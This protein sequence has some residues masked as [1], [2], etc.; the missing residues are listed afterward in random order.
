MN[1][2][3]ILTLACVAT[4]AVTSSV[5][6]TGTP[7]ITFV[8]TI[9][10]GPDSSY[11]LDNSN[12]ATLG[13]YV[14]FQA[15]E[16]TYGNELW[17][18]N[19]TTTELVKDIYAGTNGSSPDELTTIGS[20]IYFKASDAAHGSELWRTDG[21]AAGTIRLSDIRAGA[22]SSMPDEIMAIGST[23][24][25]KAVGS[26]IGAELYKWNGSSV[27]LVQDLR[28][29]ADAGSDPT[30]LTTFGDH[31]YFVANDGTHGQEL[32]RIGSTGMPELVKDINVSGGSSPGQLYAASS[33][34]YFQANDGE[35]GAEL[36]RTDGTEAGTVMVQN[37][38]GSAGS[39]P[40]WMIEFNGEIYFQATDNNAGE[41]PGR[42]LF[43]TNGPSAIE[44]VS[45][46]RDGNDGS[47]PEGL[48]VLGSRLFF[49]ADDG[50]NGTELWSY[51]GTS[52]TLF[53]LNTGPGNSYPMY[54]PPAV[55]G[56]A[57][58]FVA[59]ANESEGD[60]YRI[61]VED[62][63]PTLVA[64]SDATLH[65]SWQSCSSC[66]WSAPGPL[67]AAQGRLFFSFGYDHPSYGNE[68]AYLDEPTYVLPSTN[69]DGSALP[70]ILVFAAALTAAASTALRRR[71][72]RR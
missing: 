55:V 57:L 61:G 8:D 31:I 68:F 53:D 47:S 46:L 40:Q 69:G 51:D 60:L 22:A 37:I 15:Y 25:F 66:S 34:L 5:R 19:G 11:A 38:D 63:L 7:T 28:S 44:L 35:N 58:Y 71:T 36:W 29:G 12:T 6:A 50:V 26:G 10:P 54:M 65:S 59:S 16:S 64:P 3:R 27:S 33:A 32:W 70:R 20:Y 14:Y 41:G 39:F 52:F 72:A 23:I 48:T 62:T 24:Y 30:F 45:N 9:Y 49:Q 56:D 2:R 43:R 42:E 1:A 13:E 67:T 17:R 4:L 18:S 21:T